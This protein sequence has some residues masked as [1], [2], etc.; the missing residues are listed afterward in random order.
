LDHRGQS[1]VI[2]LGIYYLESR[3]NFPNSPFPHKNKI[4]PYFFDLIRNLPLARWTDSQLLFQNRCLP[5]SECF[6]F[7]MTT[8]LCDVAVLDIE[9]RAEIL[10]FQVT[11]LIE[12]SQLILSKRQDSENPPNVVLCKRIVPLLFGHARAMGRFS[13][14]LFLKLFPKATP[15]VL[16]RTEPSSTKNRSFSNFRSII[17]QSLST[18]IFAN[19]DPFH[20]KANGK[21]EDDSSAVYFRAFGSSF[22]VPS[23]G[24]SIQFTVSHLEAI[25]RVAQLSLLEKSVLKYLDG[26]AGE[27]F[28][29]QTASKYPYKSFSETLNLVLVTVLKQILSGHGQLPLTFMTD[30]Q[31]LV[32]SLFTSGQTELQ[33]RHFDQHKHLLMES[34]TT[35]S[36][37][38][39]ATR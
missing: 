17:P 25:L 30:I 13:A 32:R 3:L 4:L 29:S 2:A 23:H 8:L 20:S 26:L 36:S 19:I 22:E 15:P 12:I 33:S 10:D 34:K 5:T 9:A 18:T 35:S 11:F 6:A 24:H 21:E 1:A 31:E 16:V 7:S 27:T 39:S 28:S 37:L 38:T 14:P